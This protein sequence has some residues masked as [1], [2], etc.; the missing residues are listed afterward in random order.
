MKPAEGQLRQSLGHC[1]GKC[2]AWE[3]GE[4]VVPTLSPQ[5]CYWHLGVGCAGLGSAAI[6]RVLTSL[7]SHLQTFSI[8]HNAAAMI[9]SP[10]M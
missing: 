4:I 5:Y 9:A 8:P 1:S 6:F 7:H 3:Q 2:M 10:I